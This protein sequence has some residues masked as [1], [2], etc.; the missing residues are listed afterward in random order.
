MARP[1]KTTTAQTEMADVAAATAST[2][3]NGAVKK[4][5]EVFY[6]GYTTDEHGRVDKI[7]DRWPNIHRA[8][9]AI[10]PIL[11]ALRMLGRSTDIHVW[12][13]R[14]VQDDLLYPDRTRRAAAMPD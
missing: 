9:K 6:I 10:P 4:R 2:D 8:R 13:C 12:K 5:R 7:V 11:A 14:Q 1:K 3:A